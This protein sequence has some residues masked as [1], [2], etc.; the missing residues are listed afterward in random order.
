MGDICRSNDVGKG[1]KKESILK[2]TSLNLPS[3]KLLIYSVAGLRKI[4]KEERNNRK[5]FRAPLLFEG[6]PLLGTTSEGRR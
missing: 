2:R 1:Q 5:N 6:L 4:I 3:T